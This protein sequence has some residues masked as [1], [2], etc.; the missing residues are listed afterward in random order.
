VSCRVVC[1]ESLTACCPGRE[2]NTT[3]TVYGQARFSHDGVEVVTKRLT[4]FWA[5]L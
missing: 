3:S 2:G 1:E 5:G 4:Y